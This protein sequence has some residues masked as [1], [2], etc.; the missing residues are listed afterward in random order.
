MTELKPCPFCHDGGRPYINKEYLYRMWVD[1]DDSEDWVLQESYQVKCMECMTQ[2][3]NWFRTE[4]EAADAWNT[5]YE[6]TCNFK[7]DD[8]FSIAAV[9]CDC[10]AH[11]FPENDK[12][13]FKYCPNCGAR[14]VDGDAS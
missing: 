8:A 3:P 13:R 1:E 14:V 9:I 6:P 10:G 4:D 2:G 12:S 11:W 7:P 5:R